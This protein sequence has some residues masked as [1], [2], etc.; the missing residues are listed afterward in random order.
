MDLR[1]KLLSLYDKD[2]LRLR[3]QVQGSWLSAQSC[4][5]KWLGVAIALQC[6]LTILWAQ[7]S[8]LTNL[9]E[10]VPT[11]KRLTDSSIRWTVSS[12]V[13]PPQ[14]LHA[15]IIIVPFSLLSLSP[16]AFFGFN[17]TYFLLQK[18]VSCS[19]VL[20]I[21]VFCHFSQYQLYVRD[22]ASFLARVSFKLI[23]LWPL[24]PANFWWVNSVNK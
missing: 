7:I 14:N 2:F 12:F 19:C 4:H 8:L 5:P 17:H 22:W 20:L 13:V 10:M 3:R 23:H 16:P 9:R 18:W 21:I 6:L 24:K 15:K 11:A 1:F